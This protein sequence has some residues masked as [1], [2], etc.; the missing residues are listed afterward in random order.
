MRVVGLL[1]VTLGVGITGCATKPKPVL[2]AACPPVKHEL[3]G[4]AVDH[5]LHAT[6]DVELKRRFG[7][8][9]THVLLD[10]ETDARGDLIVTANR[11]GPGRFEMPEVGKGGGVR[12]V[13]RACTAKVLTVRKLAGLESK[14]AAR[15]PNEEPAT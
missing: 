13:M 14:P 1:V 10:R 6:F 9:G 11:I 5:T 15:A 4:P 12:V 2:A 3:W 7:E 8:T